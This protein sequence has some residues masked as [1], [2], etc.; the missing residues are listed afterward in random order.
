MT[1]NQHEEYTVVLLITR[2]VASQLLDYREVIEAVESAHAALALGHAAQAA[3]DNLEVPDSDV[4][5]VPMLAASAPHRA[6][7]LKLL[8]DAP[9]NPADGAPRQQSVILLIDAQ[10][11]CEA[12]LDGAAITLYRT[13]A[14]S[15][16]ATKHLAR[17]DATTLGI[18]GA[19]AQAWAH[20]NAICHVRR[21]DH[22]VIWSR[23]PEA[24]NALAARAEALGA[25]ASTA[26]EARRVVELS[27]IVCTLTPAIDPL[28]D[29][30]WLHPGMHLNVVGSPPRREH[31]EVDTG[32]LRRSRIVVDDRSVALAESGAIR[33]AIEDGSIDAET[34]DADLGAVITGLRPGRATSEQI[35]LYNSV[36]VGIQDIV[37]ARFV[38]DAADK[39][40]LGDTVNLAD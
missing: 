14:A 31:R 7:G 20:L 13:A 23:R 12:I 8:A 21:I 32:V 30:E 19:G 15:A 6:A 22:V 2:S 38:V 40:G 34:L 5:L 37:T 16:V 11:R 10:G 18:I 33:A 3:R 1:A 39:A 17:E 25:T 28:I 27:D 29:G 36:G 4:L 24:A 9:G 26:A 35:T